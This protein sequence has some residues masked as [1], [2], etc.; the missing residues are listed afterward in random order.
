M[1]P[2]PIRWI[3]DPTGRFPERPYVSQEDLDSLSEEWMV[4]FL[5]EMYGQSRVPCVH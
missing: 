4:G 5:L 3:K 1:R 2:N